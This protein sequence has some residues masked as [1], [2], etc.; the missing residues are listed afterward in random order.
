MP[1][2][3][4]VTPKLWRLPDIFQFN[5]KL[6]FIIRLTLAKLFFW[7]ILINKYADSSCLCWPTS[8]CKVR[9]TGVP[10]P[11]FIDQENNKKFCLGSLNLN[12]L[13]SI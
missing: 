9:C 10:V 7:R 6:N 1:L 5:N 8:G 12:K 2:G 11:I 13:Q 4:S 3:G